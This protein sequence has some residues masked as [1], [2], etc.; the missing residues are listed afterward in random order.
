MKRL[1]LVGIVT[2]SLLA[3]MIPY[4][5]VNAEGSVGEKKQELKDVQKEQKD[6]KETL[7]ELKSKIEPH[8]KK[9]EKMEKKISQINKKIQKSEKENKKNEK[10]LKKYDQL[11]KDR[12]RLIYAKGEMG[13]MQ[14]LLESED[15]GEFL[16]RFETLRLILM[17]DKTLF[18]KYDKVR[19]EHEKLKKELSDLRKKQ[20]KEAEKTRKVYDEINKEIAK[21]Q[22][23]LASLH[24]K[25]SSIQEEINRLTLVDASLYPYKYASTSGVDPWGFY[26]RQCTS[27]VAWRLN[28]QGVRFTNT[29]RG[30]RFGNAG[31]WDD[32]ARALGI[33]VD[34]RPAVG[35]VAQFNPGVGGASSVYG[36]VAFVTAVH[37]STIT[38]EEYNH[39]PYAFSR[40]VIPV[41]SVSNFIHMN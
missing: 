2:S 8:K 23:K 15:F 19:K 10:K 11:F 41:S 5:T 17:R 6:T 1:L 32:N 21:A 7:K 30:G 3:G 14:A 29:M 37:G 24:S 40:R 35:A 31:N 34:K 39:R 38:I 16:E 12:V 33:R 27:F 28:Q 22:E 36:H 18:N 25:E 9:V 20:E 4:Q 26:I 13:S